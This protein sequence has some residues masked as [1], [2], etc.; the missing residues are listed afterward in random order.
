MMIKS[1]VNKAIM[2]IALAALA[3]WSMHTGDK[4]TVATIVGA[5]IMMLKAD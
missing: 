3:L 1:T 2:L 5:F 4:V